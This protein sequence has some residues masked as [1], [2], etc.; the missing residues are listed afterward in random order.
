MGETLDLLFA[1]VLIVGREEEEEAE[2]RA[3]A[4]EGKPRSPFAAYSRTSDAHLE[5]DLLE[6]GPL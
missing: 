3:R 6:G 4:S 5:E 1:W 2:E